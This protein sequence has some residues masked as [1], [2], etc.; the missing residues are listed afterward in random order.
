V[1]VQVLPVALLQAPP[2][3]CK[4]WPAAGVAVS[5]MFVFA[6]TLALHALPQLM[7]PTGEA[8][9]PL[10]MTLTDT[11]WVTGIAAKVAVT[12]VACVT[13]TVQVLPMALLQAPPQDCRLWPA[14]GVAVNVTFVL[15]VT[16]VLHTVPQLMLPEAVAT[17]PLPLT[18]TDTL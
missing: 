12:E 1:T 16:F 3:D 4:V 2:Q 15:A 9:E 17:A 8:T 14:D 18:L 11:A 13:V 7:L 5:V 10:P 6:N